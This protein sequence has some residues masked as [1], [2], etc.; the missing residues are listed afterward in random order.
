M[1]N[2]EQ[3]S[4]LML[5]GVFV[6]CLTASIYTVGWSF[7]YHFFAKFNLGLLDLNIPREYFFLYAFQAIQENILIFISPLL[8]FACLYGAAVLIKE[9]LIRIDTAF[10]NTFM[11]IIIPLLFLFILHISYN[12]GRLA[13]DSIYEKEAYPKDGTVC[14]PSYP[15]VKIWMKQD[16]KK[17]IGEI[18]GEWEKG[19]YRLLTSNNDSFF[20]FCPKDDK[21]DI[22]VE[23][24][25]ESNVKG[26]RILPFVTD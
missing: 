16:A 26:V 21:E 6:T 19:S 2:I 3:N 23:I 10:R 4:G 7:A 24:I 22:P 1:D 13:A 5:F 14:F 9:D 18:A 25:P 12:T 11:I 20:I 15:A 17:G 8:F